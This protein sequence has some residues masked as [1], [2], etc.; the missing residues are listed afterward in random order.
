MFNIKLNTPAH[1]EKKFLDIQKTLNGDYILREHPDIDIIVIPEKFKILIL[2]KR[3]LTEPVYKLQ[4]KL[5]SFLSKKGVILPE[6]IKGGNVFG[7]LE[8]TYPQSP[9]G[10]ENPLQ[11]V[12]YDISN[13]IDQERPEYLYHQEYQ[14]TM[15]DYLLHPDKK[16][17]TELG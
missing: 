13:F 17:S 4:E 3:D 16:D 5:F 1:S 14:K 9:P 11:V 8:A 7:S 15:E 10:G 2:T 12:V 6:T